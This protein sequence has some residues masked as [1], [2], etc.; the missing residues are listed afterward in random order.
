MRT[1]APP[2]LPIFRS[3]LQARLLAVLL[4]GGGTAQT[5][6]ALAERTGASA[7]S[8]HREL[9]RLEAAGI[10]DHERVGRTK[11]YRAVTASP[12]H[13]PLRELVE[14]TLGVQELLRAAVDRVPGVEAAA[15]FGSW[16]AGHVSAAS[17]VD[18][19]VVGE[20]DRA[21]LLREVREVE[22]IA[23]REVSVTAF[24]PAEFE[25]RR[26]ADAGF[27]ATVLRRPTILLVGE[28]P[29]A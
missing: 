16:A 12:V 3:D 4:L 24:E 14:R 17:D 8:L 15:I 25:R 6:R 20:V 11:V 10:V 9:H 23:G 19:L 29:R 27:V 5:T 7:A 1:V 26:R 21:R 2:L 13:E 18:L 22:R 28:L